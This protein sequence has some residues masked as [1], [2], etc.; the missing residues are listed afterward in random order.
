MEL[1]AAEPVYRLKPDGGKQRLVLG[2]QVEGEKLS[3]RIEGVAF[4]ALPPTNWWPG[5]VPVF[6][7]ER[8]DRFELRRTPPR[9]QENF[10]EPLFFA[11]P[12][13]DE[14]DAARIVGRWECSATREGGTESWFTWEL[15][16]DGDKLAGRFD[17]GTDYRVAS[18]AGGTFRSNRFTLNIEYNL[19]RYELTGEWRDGALSGRWRQVGESENGAW[20]AKRVPQPAATN[21]FR[22]AVAL[23]EFRRASGNTRHY[24]T[25]PALP[26]TGWERAARPLFRVWLAA[27]NAVPKEKLK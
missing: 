24:S 22:A 16:A 3:A 27:T 15:T 2:E 21:S 25:E 8:E 5:L 6:G 23:H 11:L 26:E 9:G 13:E 17:Q 20:E 7:V 1:S 14:P 12:P 10:T 18:V 4:L 19:D